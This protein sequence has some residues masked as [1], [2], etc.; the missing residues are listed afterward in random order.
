[1]KTTNSDT[2]KLIQTT[3]LQRFLR[4]PLFAPILMLGLLP[5]S[6][7]WTSG[8]GLTWLFWPT[9]PT[10][11]IFLWMACGF[12]ILTALIRANKE[13]ASVG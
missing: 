1:M 3:K 11:V 5:A 12:C 13:T 2:A 4:D 6:F 10:L 9:M 8:A 7:N